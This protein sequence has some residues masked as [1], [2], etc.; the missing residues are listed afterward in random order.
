MCLNG[1]LSTNNGGFK[2]NIPW[3]IRD[4]YIDFHQERWEIIV[5]VWSLSWFAYIY[6]DM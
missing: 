1:N 5:G 6:I 3:H 4:V 2:E